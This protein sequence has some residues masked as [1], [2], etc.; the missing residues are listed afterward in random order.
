RGAA[1]VVARGVVVVTILVRVDDAVTAHGPAAVETA[2][3]S[4]WIHLVVVPLVALFETVAVD[5]AVAAALEDTRGAT[6]VTVVDIA[7]VAA[8]VL[9]LSDAVTAAELDAGDLLARRGAA[10]AR[11]GRVRA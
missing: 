5:N 10:L 6:S 1:A 4:R 8:L 2:A 9:G 3:P 7:V 11:P